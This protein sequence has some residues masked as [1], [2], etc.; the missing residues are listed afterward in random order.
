MDKSREEKVKSATS[1]LE[2]GANWLVLCG[3][4]RIHGEKYIDEKMKEMGVTSLPIYG[5][6][7]YEE[8]FSMV[9]KEKSLGLIKEAYRSHPYHKEIMLEARRLKTIRSVVMERA[10]RG[11]S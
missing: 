8:L 11:E 5:L 2:L 6:D 9:Q 4:K 7:T 10:R 3:L 1:D